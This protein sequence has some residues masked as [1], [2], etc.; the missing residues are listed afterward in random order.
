MLADTPNTIVYMIAGYAVL[1]GLPLLYVA[2]WFLRRRNLEKDL[3]VIR[4][5]AEDKEPA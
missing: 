3:D 1:L 4:S 2:S 5:I